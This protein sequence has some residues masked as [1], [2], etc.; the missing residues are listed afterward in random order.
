MKLLQLFLPLSSLLHSLNRL[1]STSHIRH[2]TRLRRLR[3]PESLIYMR[4]ERALIFDL[5]E[6]LLLR[7]LHMDLLL[8]LTHVLAQLVQIIELVSRVR[9]QILAPYL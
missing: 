5:L 6:V 7:G 9:H 8:E 2:S 1:L 3:T 4:R